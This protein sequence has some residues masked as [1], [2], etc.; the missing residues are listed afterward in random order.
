M[1]PRDEPAS[2]DTSGSDVRTDGGAGRVPVRTV[3][4]IAIAL[5]AVSCALS[6]L[7]AAHDVS[8]RLGTPH[9]LW[10]PALWEITSG[11][12]IA[13]L[14]P[15]VR[16][17]AMLIRASADRLI[18]VGLVA[19]AGLGFVYSTLHIVG[20]GLLRELAYR[21]GGWTYTFPWSTQF[22]Y[23]MRKD[24]LAYCGLV[25]MFWLADRLTIVTEDNAG[26]KPD[27]TE[28]PAAPQEIWLRDG[29]TSVLIDPAEI[30]SVTSA[31]NYVEYRLTG[32]RTHLVRATLQA[33]EDRLAR[34]GIVRVHRTRLVNLKRI[35]ALEWRQSGDFEVRLDTG[36]TV[37]CSRRFRTAVAH[38]AA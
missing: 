32:N 1:R 16:R 23:E 22:P 11:T 13:A 18:A 33:Q 24:L 28:R 7:S 38:I 15:L 10:E 29:R 6:G 34:L 8:G 25:A 4:A 12:V 30:I 20:M 2:T 36:E 35:V 26:K 37:A 19:A 27:I 31:G 5:V 3:Y 21:L 17:A 9:N 14:L